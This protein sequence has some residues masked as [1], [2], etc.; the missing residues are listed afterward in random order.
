[1]VLSISRE[2]GTSFAREYI[3]IYTAINDYTCDIDNK[4]DVIKLENY[5]KLGGEFKMVKVKALQEFTYGN[6]N[7]ITNLVRYDTN[8][9]KDGRL[10]AGDVFECTKDMAKYLTGGCGYTLVKV[11]E[12]IP[13]E[14]PNKEEP[15]IKEKITKP[16]KTTKKKK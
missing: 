10:Y 15:I 9:D 8:K 2:R 1:M 13:E 16:K 7:K 6:F 3:Y 5:L 14:K 4:D 11:I 12:V